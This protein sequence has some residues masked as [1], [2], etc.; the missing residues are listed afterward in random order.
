MM[1]EVKNGAVQVEDDQIKGTFL[2]VHFRFLVGGERG[3]G[4]GDQ[5]LGNRVI[6]ICAVYPFHQ[7]RIPIPHSHNYR[8]DAVMAGQILTQF[9]VG[10]LRYQFVHKVE[11]SLALVVGD[12]QEDRALGT[13]ITRRFFQQIADGIETVVACLKGQLRLKVAHAVVQC[14]I[15][16][17]G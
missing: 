8:H 2:W 10:C 17:G 16:A 12:L 13:Q 6:A 15:V 3:L 1:V 9:H 11:Y 4:I 5:G 14:V 7:S